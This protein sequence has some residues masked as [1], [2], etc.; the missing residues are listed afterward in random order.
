[1]VFLLPCSWRRSWIQKG[2]LSG[3][4]PCQSRVRFFQYWHEVGRRREDCGEG[5]FSSVCFGFVMCF[6][7]EREKMKQNW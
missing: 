6:C 1:M 4:N 3:D 7:R 5:S 2:H